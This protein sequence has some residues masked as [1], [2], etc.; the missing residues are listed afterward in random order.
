MWSIDSSVLYIYTLYV[1]YRSDSIHTSLTRWY[2][3]FFFLNSEPLQPD[4]E[5]L[6][7]EKVFGKM[8]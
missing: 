7:K 1:Y 3:G 4:S 5:N 2:E 6:L 8:N